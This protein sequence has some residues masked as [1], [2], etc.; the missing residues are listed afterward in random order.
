MRPVHAG[1]NIFTN[2]LTLDRADLQ[3]QIA[4]RF[5][6]AVGTPGLLDC[7]L[8]NP[9][10]ALDGQNN[11]LR[12]PLDARIRTPFLAQAMSGSL[13]VSSA[14]RFDMG[15]LTLRLQAPRAERIALQGLSGADA[16]QLLQAGG[17]LAA[18]ALQDYPLHTFRPE[19]MRV[20]NRRF[21][22]E[23]ITVTETGLTVQLV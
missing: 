22:V 12:V 18:E 14:L 1:Y 8:S 17:A 2:Q 7:V 10:L 16:A 19:E 15:S 9:R 21:A 11:R 13:T 23:S 20:G 3:A 5:P 4:R 6:L